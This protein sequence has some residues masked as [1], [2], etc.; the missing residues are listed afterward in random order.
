MTV[1][2][3]IKFIHWSLH[4]CRILAIQSNNT[5]YQTYY[6][7]VNLSKPEPVEPLKVT[8]VSQVSSD[9]P[10]NR[11][12]YIMFS[13]TDGNNTQIQVSSEN[14]VLLVPVLSPAKGP[15]QDTWDERRSYDLLVGRGGVYGV[16]VFKF[17]SITGEDPPEWRNG[18]YTFFV[19]INKRINN[20]L[21]QGS[22]FA[23]VKMEI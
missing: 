11:V 16:R 8:A 18:V 10:E 4:T 23:S 1:I 2:G 21:A 7:I 12:I 3:W 13:I 14:D 20:T 19:K 6:L 5:K 9:P 17:E 15:Y 22:T